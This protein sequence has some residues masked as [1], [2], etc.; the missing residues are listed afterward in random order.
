MNCIDFVD[1]KTEV[2]G[3]IGNPV[4]KSFSPVLQNTLA[5]ELG[6]ST[7]YVPFKV[8]KGR[9]KTAIEGGQALGIKGPS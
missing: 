5:H 1:G 7:V 2:F 3:I 8:D 9:V 6:K 4:E